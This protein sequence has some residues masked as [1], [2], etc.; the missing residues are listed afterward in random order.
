MKNI[1]LQHWTGDLNKLAIL[2][3]TN[4]LKYASNVGA[5]YRLLRGNVFNPNLSP[6]CQKLYML[7]EEFDE[8]DIVVMIDMDV[9]TRKGMEENIFTDAK[10]VGR[11]NEANKGRFRY[12]QR[13]FPHLANPKYPFWGGSIYRVEREVRQ[14]LRA[15]TNEKEMKQF[16]PNMVNFGG[17]LG[18]E[19]IMHRLASLAQLNLKEP[20]IPERWNH[21]SYVP[22]VEN[23]ATIHVRTKATP[24]GPK[25]PKIENYK[26]LVRQGLIE[27]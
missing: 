15:H 24:K 5:E 9:F 6:P 14:R 20:F 7:N 23:A 22:G 25:R 21:G 18:D 17:D 27:E 13:K 26:E 2:S 16:S 3:S 11:C 4:I 1:I 19:G 10:G 12:L 8:Y